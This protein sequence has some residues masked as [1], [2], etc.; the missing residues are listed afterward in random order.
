MRSWG[1]AKVELA[2]L[3]GGKLAS[4][5]ELEGGRIKDGETR[6]LGI[7]SEK[8]RVEGRLRGVGG[9]GGLRSLRG[10]R[11]RIKELGAKRDSLM[12]GGWGGS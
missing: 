3:R 6:L 10:I 4:A 5:D 12:R 9:G 8:L 7:R 2:E 11:A 1:R